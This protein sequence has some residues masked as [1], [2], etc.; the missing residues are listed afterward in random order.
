M[1]TRGLAKRPRHL[2]LFLLPLLIGV[3][4]SACAPPAGG[5]AAGAAE[6]PSN[7]DS[8]DLLQPPFSLGADFPL[9]RPAAG[10]PA[11]LQEGQPAPVFSMA[12][13][14]TEQL[15][16]ADLQGRALVINFWA[17]WCG[18]CRHEIPLLLQAQ[19]QNL[20]ELIVLAVNIKEDAEAVRKFAD[21]FNMNVPVVL[22]PDGNVVRQFEVIGYPTSYFV[23]ADG[24]LVAKWQGVLDRTKL[25]E[26][27]QATLERGT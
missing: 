22:D 16:T 2:I 21:E 6:F 25:A 3:W 20:E 23:D 8:A 12:F 17:S 15:T 7:P 14:E 5:D 26:L 13:S 10:R 27:V 18:P 9:G 11:A 19:E 1:K 24:L 4:V